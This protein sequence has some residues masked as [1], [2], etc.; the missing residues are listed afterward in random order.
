MCHVV[1]TDFLNMGD[2]FGDGDGDGV[3]GAVCGVIELIC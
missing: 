3:W 2:E 1:G